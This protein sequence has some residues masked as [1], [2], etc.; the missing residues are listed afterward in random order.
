MSRE[1]ASIC[2][3]SG[4]AVKSTNG[5][6]RAFETLPAAERAKVVAYVGRI[7]ETDDSWIPE[8][9]RQG[10]AEAAAGR[11]TD[12]ETVLNEPPPLPREP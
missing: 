9:F 4:T 7:M 11:L 10:M 3:K 8:S 1:D 2:S 5:P 6:D 12:M